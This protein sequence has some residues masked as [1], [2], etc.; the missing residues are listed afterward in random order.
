MSAKENRIAIFMLILLMISAVFC[1]SFAGASA[2]ASLNVAA[3]EQSM[4]QNPD[5]SGGIY[6]NVPIVPSSAFRLA[7]R[8]QRNHN[9]APGRVRP[10][11]PAEFEKFEE[12]EKRISAPHVCYS[13]IEAV[14]CQKAE[15]AIVT[16]P[17]RAGPEKQLLFT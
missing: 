7:L 13:Q 15:N 9:V 8:N 5:D 16:S 14:K 10:W 6:E 3:A 17:V 1:C 11:T 4:P 2:E 12:L